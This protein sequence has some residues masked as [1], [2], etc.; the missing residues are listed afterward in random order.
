[1][2]LDQQEIVTI[3]KRIHI[4]R[5]VEDPVL[6]AVAALM[7]EV[8]IGAGE[9]VFEQ[10]AEPDYFYII[11][12]G[13]VQLTRS[14][15]R[16]QVS[17]GCLE[18]DDYFGEEILENAWPRQMTVE[19]VVDTTLLRI[20]GDQFIAMLGLIEPLTGRLQFILDSYKLALRQSPT[21]DWRGSDE[22][23]LFIARRHVLFL[24]AGML[25]PTI[26]G[27]LA[28]PAMAYLWV[29]SQLMITFL[30]LAV[31]TLVDLI[32]MVWSFVDW[33]NDYYIV[34]SQ[35]IVYKER[36]VLIYDSR[37]E[38][39]LSAIQS[40]TI[41]TSLWGR[42][43]KFGNVAIRTFYGVLLFR[44][45]PNPEQVMALIQQV[46]L[47]AQFFQHKSDLHG[48]RNFME[49]RIQ[50]G[51]QRPHPPAPRKPAAKPEPMREFLSTLFHLRWQVG[52]TIM[53]RTHWFI[54]LQK[55]FLPSLAL[56]GIITVFV[57]SL[58]N[59]FQTLSIQ[60]TCGLIFVTGLI[61]FG[62]WLYQY[63]DWHNDLYLITIDQVVDVNKKPLG[64]E[65]RQ[66]AP[67]RNILSIEFKR[68]GL[69]GLILNYGTVYIRVGDRQLTFDSVYKPSDVQRELFH[70]LA[71]VNA[72]EKK[73]Q[74]ES[75]KQR[76][77]DWF[78]TYNE[79]VRQNP[80]GQKPP[81][82]SAPPGVHSGF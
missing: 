59:R 58:L 65:E 9:R 70:R 52:K 26:V 38:S 8:E 33:S 77:G 56:A 46:Q 40:T 76:F 68:V 54:L 7:E 49:E 39:P 18:D 27:F 45:I 63:M 14:I 74:A 2:A 57:L 23:V 21:F 20:S 42:L 69:I 29:Q 47:R 6:E 12:S 19:T 66:A 67:I 24:I 50:R 25:A 30:M 1:M 79:Y 71:E 17:L 32:W 31:V 15:G 28:I 43:Y 61:A 81:P 16:D 75:D 10:N 53:Y 36:V 13:R 64:H 73:A 4:F 41:N 48:I 22:A 80:P 5:A 35:R 72:E 3:L 34:T 78:A 51:L 44:S 11:A 62:W 55:I 37:Q 60:A 82:R